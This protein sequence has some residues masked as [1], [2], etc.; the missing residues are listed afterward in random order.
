MLKERLTRN[1][2]V[3]LTIVILLSGI[4]GL[5]IIII[6]LIDINSLYPPGEFHS[7]V[8]AVVFSGADQNGLV[9]CPWI[10]N[11]TDDS[12]VGENQEFRD[13]VTEELSAEIQ[14][15]SLI[16]E[17]KITYTGGWHEFDHCLQTN[18][19]HTPFDPF[20]VHIYF[21]YDQSTRSNNN[22]WHYKI[23]PALEVTFREKWYISQFMI[24]LTV[25]AL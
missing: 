1:Q 5:P 2:V 17:F 3:I 13:Y 9:A 8:A 12:V 11:E 25:V 15:Y 14:N 6:Y 10:L 18:P 24:I 19:N 7:T 20:Y 16:T 22:L 4:I 23:A 21:R